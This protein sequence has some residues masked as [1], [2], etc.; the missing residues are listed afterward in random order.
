MTLDQIRERLLARSPTSAN[1]ARSASDVLSMTAAETLALAAPIYVR[2]AKG[3]RIVDVDGNEYI[4][5]IT[6][7]GP[8]L[9]GH[10]PDQVVEA[11]REAARD[12]LQF[13]LPNRHQEPLARLIVESAPCADRVLFCSTGTEATMFAIRA[14]RAFTGRTKIAV[15]EGGYHGAHDYVLAVVDQDSPADAPTFSPRKSGIPGETLSTVMMLPYWNDAALDLI[16][17]H[18]HELA[19]VMIEPVQGANAQSEHVAWLRGLRDV[20]TEAGVPLVFDEVITGFRL[21]IGGAQTAFGVVPELATYG[22]VLGGGLPIGAV[23][24]RADIMDTFSKH[25][26]GTYPLEKEAFATGTF[27]SNPMSMTAGYATISHLRDHPQLY[28]HLRE[29]SDRLADTVN[30]FCAAEAI[31]ARVNHNQSILNIYF[32]HDANARTVRELRRT[33]DEPGPSGQPY[34]VAADAFRAYLLEAGVIALTMHHT[35]LS[36]AHTQRDVDLVIE[37]MKGAL[38]KVRADGLC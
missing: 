9:L 26:L 28:D 6:G 36:T 4:D 18:R 8:H 29:Q 3:S 37:A 7:F 17:R 12:G 32:G 15:F 22:K 24:G 19:L 1:L 11:I 33:Q 5:L 21:G 16:R 23:A 13:G 30:A 27:N 2:S 35:H 20:C 25:A 10:A 38:L 34:S 14:L 31:P